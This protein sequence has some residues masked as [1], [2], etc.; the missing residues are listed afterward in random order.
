MVE[1]T[2][3]SGPGVRVE[4]AVGLARD[5]R[6]VDVADAEH[7]GALL[8]RVAYGHEGVHRLAGL[9][10]R[11]HQ[12]GAGEDGVAVAELAGQLDLARDLRPVLDGVLGDHARVMR[13]AAG[14]DDDLVDVAQLVVREAHLVEAEPPV[15]ADP[16]E[17][18]VGDR[19]RLLGDLLQHE[20]VVAALLGGGDVPVD[21]V[22]LDLGGLA[23][24]VGDRHARPAQLHDLVLAQ[25]D[26]V[27]GVRDEGGD[28]AGEEVLAVADA[29]DERGVA[30]GADDDVGL[31]G[32]DRD[33]R[34]RALQPA[35]DVPH[36]VGQPG[37]LG[38]LLRQQVRDPSVS[39]SEDSSW[40]RRS[41]SSRRAAKFSMMPLCTT[42]TAPV[43]SVCGWALRSVGGPWVAHR[44]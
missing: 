30:A 40:P 25:L 11:D 33:Q 16:A 8:A 43:Q 35:A 15:G 9:G 32:V 2:A 4:H 22:L 1:A 26:R 6:A 42:A 12:G 17:Q 34:E 27:A 7:A 38:D 31:A 10:D 3:I 23:G 37:A 18:R 14:H 39:V 24:E 44:V 29:D 20:V 5:R 21:V 41:S 28:V 13:G 19:A 36:R